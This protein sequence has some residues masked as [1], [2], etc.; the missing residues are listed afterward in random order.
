MLNLH[1][2]EGATVSDDA[3]I[4]RG[5][6]YCLVPWGDTLISTLSIENKQK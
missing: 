5:G 4:S 1:S 6:A 3:T 2:A